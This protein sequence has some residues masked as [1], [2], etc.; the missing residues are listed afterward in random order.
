MAAIRFCILLALA[1]CASAPPEL[2][3]DGEE[4]LIVTFPAW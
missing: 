2:I 4:E 1:G 3:T